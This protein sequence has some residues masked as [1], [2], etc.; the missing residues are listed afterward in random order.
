MMNSLHAPSA[1]LAGGLLI[2]AAVGVAF[3][4]GDDPGSGLARGAIVAA[5]ALVLYFG[6]RRR[7]SR[8]DLR[9]HVDRGGDRAGAAGM[10]TARSSATVASGPS[11]T[12]AHV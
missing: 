9:V 8:R 5:I 7:E 4:I 11:K 2:A 10:R 3:L 6:R 1:R 12:S